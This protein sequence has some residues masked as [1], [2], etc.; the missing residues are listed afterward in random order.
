MQHGVGVMENV[1]LGD[2]GIAVVLLILPQSPVGQGVL[3]VAVIQGSAFGFQCPF[4]GYAT[5]KNI[6]ELKG[7]MKAFTKS[8]VAAM[9]PRQADCTTEKRGN[10]IFMAGKQTQLT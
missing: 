8:R 1:A 10:Y 9:E 5:L 4:L 7:S 3:A 6:H 2:G